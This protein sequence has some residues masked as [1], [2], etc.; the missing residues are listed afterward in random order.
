MRELFD[1][2]MHGDITSPLAKHTNYLVDTCF[3]Y[4]IFISHEKEFIEFC[5]NNAV[6]ITSFNIEEVLFHSHDVN[7]HIRNRIRSAI[8]NKINLVA[9]YMK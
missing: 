7:H 4:Q 8:K 6:G 3:L 9:F 5:K 2:L 1:L